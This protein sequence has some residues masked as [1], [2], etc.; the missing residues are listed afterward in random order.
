MSRRG[1]RSRSCRSRG[2][3]S[4]SD[5]SRWGMCRCCGKCWHGSTGRWWRW[6]RLTFATV[7][8]TGGQFRPTAYR[9][10][11]E[12]RINFYRDCSG[13]CDYAIVRDGV[14]GCS[15]CLA[16]TKNEGNKSGG[17]RRIRRIEN[18]KSTYDLVFLRCGLREDRVDAYNHFQPL[19]LSD[20]RRR[21]TDQ[22]YHRQVVF[23]CL[24][25]L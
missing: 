8:Y 18:Q 10:S 25:L 13:C 12:N 4:G 21:K 17:E 24:R 9:I 11:V 7:N 6:L 19:T 23:L 5:G 16:T 20:G 3:C 1:C 2:C 14:R 15:C 22:T